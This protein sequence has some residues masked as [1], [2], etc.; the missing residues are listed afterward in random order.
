MIILKILFL[1]AA[2]TSTVFAQKDTNNEF[3]LKRP[4]N[5]VQ[6]KLDPF[7]PNFFKKIVRQRET[8]RV[9]VIAKDPVE[10]IFDV[11]TYNENYKLVQSTQYQ[12]DKD[13]EGKWRFRFFSG[14]YVDEDLGEII[15]G[16]ANDKHY[17][18][19]GVTGIEIGVVVY[20][21]FN[22]WPINLIAQIGI[23]KH[24]E[25]GHQQDFFA[26]TLGVKAEWTSFP[27]ND[28]VRTKISMMEGLNYANE[29]PYFEGQE[30][31]RGN[32]QRDS[33]LLNYLGL[34]ISGNM[35]DLFQKGSL[36]HCYIG[37]YLYHRSGVF[38][39]IDSFNNVKGGSNF[40][41][42]SVECSF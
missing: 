20:K 37:A 36:D 28:H 9:E 3:V 27:W 29:V 39:R 18:K 10:L 30:V 40:K 4:P 33:K 25:R 8:Y 1:V 38:A 13:A 35:G 34:G 12:A 26:T 22:G 32:D 31:R 6:K 17:G 42:I 2:L 23:A 14:D 7:D 41:T 21:D 19:T 11:N 24:H 16:E 15:L 5:Q